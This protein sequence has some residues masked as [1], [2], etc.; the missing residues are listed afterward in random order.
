MVQV[1][2]RE[3]QRTPILVEPRAEPCQDLAARDHEPIGRSHGGI[4]VAHECDPLRMLH[5]LDRLL[6]QAKRLV[7]P[8]EYRFLDPRMPAR[9][10]GRCHGRS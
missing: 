7:E 1:D 10:A 3:A 2:A 9:S 8:P 6:A 4:E 5:R